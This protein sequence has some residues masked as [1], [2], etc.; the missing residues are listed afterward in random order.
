MSLRFFVEELEKIARESALDRFRREQRAEEMAE[1][2]KSTKPGATVA[3]IVGGA[4][5]MTALPAMLSA[6]PL[7]TDI[8][9]R[10]IEA[11]RTKEEFALFELL[12]KK[13]PEEDPRR[14][15]QWAQEIQKAVQLTPSPEA[16][17]ELR[18]VLGFDWTHHARK[19]LE[20]TEGVKSLLESKG[21]PEQEAERLGKALT[22]LLSYERMYGREALEKGLMPPSPSE[23]GR[24]VGEGAK[25]YASRTGRELSTREVLP[26]IIGRHAK[27]L[28][29]ALAP[30]AII[31]GLGGMALTMKK[32]KKL[33]Q[34]QRGQ[35]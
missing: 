33:K 6:I 17:L 30:F 32:R 4:A 28:G 27:R 11:Q 2:Q 25:A 31:G 3:N 18:R 35:A 7:A 20:S 14:V 19:P 23:Y 21:I 13:N 16:Q 5:A 12:K 22:D 26:A 9:G 10:K 24:L 1:L 8:P 34:M 15:R 29:V